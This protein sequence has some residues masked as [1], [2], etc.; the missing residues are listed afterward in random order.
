MKRLILLVLL[1]SVPACAQDARISVAA[2]TKYT[3]ILSPDEV[4]HGQDFLMTLETQLA[5][6]FVAAKDVDYLDRNNLDA[7]FREVHLSSNSVFDQSTGAL[8]GLLGRLD[9]LI[10]IEASEASTARI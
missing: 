4:R 3:G 10:I 1:S 7:L 9:F 2:V 6:N 5:A 8:R